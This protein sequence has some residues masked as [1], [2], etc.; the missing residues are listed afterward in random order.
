P[1]REVVIDPVYTPRVDF[2]HTCVTLEANEKPQRG[3]HHLRRDTSEA[4]AH[5]HAILYPYSP[6]VNPSPE[7]W[8]AIRW[9]GFAFLR[10]STGD[11]PVTKCIPPRYDDMWDEYQGQYQQGLLMGKRYHIHPSGFLVDD[12]GFVADR[13]TAFALVSRVLSHYYGCSGG[14]I[15]QANYDTMD[16]HFGRREKQPTP[17]PARTP[18]PGFV[19]LMSNGR[20]YKVGVTNDP[21]RR[22]KE[23]EKA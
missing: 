10:F 7:P 23:I 15:E 18:R 4:P 8:A 9:Q 5:V 20:Y 3:W 6:I 19:Y 22:R 1:P 16:R 13:E 14:E 11:Y 2:V 21:E 17:T 12:V